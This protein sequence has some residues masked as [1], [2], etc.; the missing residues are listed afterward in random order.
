M[1]LVSRVTGQ[2]VETT[3]GAG[4]GAPPGSLPDTRVIPPGALLLVGMDVG[5][6]RQTPA[7]RLAGPGAHEKP[8]R[9]VEVPRPPFRP[10]A[11]VET[12][13]LGAA[14]LLLDRPRDGD[15]PAPA[16]P[17]A[18][19]PKVARRPP[20]RPVVTTRPPLVAGTQVVGL[21]PGKAITVARKPRPR[22]A[23]A[24]AG[25]GV[26]EIGTA[27]VP[28]LPLGR[29]SEDV[30]DAPRPRR[31]GA[32]YTRVATHSARAGDTAPL[33]P[34][35]PL[36][37]RRVDVGKRATKEPVPADVARRPSPGLVGPPIKALPYTAVNGE[38]ALLWGRPLDRRL[39]VLRPGLPSS[40]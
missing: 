30:L 1:P 34:G 25:G 21:P 36:R 16:S 11:I 6:A 2:P 28:P 17:L 24:V 38:G 37:G 10:D 35:R 7:R 3:L 15:G 12:V 22:H 40:I 13:G 9:P 33:G 18:D 26:A 39:V 4:T 29:P 8:P 5:T 31:P 20:P 23:D 27:R 14:V 19:A 32:S